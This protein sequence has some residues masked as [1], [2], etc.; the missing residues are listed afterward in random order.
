VIRVEEAF[1]HCAKA[2]RRARLWDPATKI[3]RARFP[4]LGR[5]I[6]D[7]LAGYTAEDAD[8]RI[9]TAYRERMY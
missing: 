5:I 6:A 3:E 1:F 4:S 9:E 7:Q 2:L 8:A